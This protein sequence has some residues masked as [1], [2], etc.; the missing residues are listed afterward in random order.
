MEEFVKDFSN[1]LY[2]AQ[3][4]TPVGKRIRLIKT[5]DKFTKLKPGTEGTVKSV[6]GTGTLH[7]K[8]DDGSNLGLIPG[9][10]EYQIL[11]K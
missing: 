11:E 5:D 9:E 3:I 8:W 7:I 6:D 1:F 4:P 2:E 10:D